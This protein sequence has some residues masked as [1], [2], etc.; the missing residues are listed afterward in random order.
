MLMYDI[1]RKKRD[2]EELSAAEIA[3]WIKGCV[4]GTIPDYQTTALLMAGRIR[5]FSPAETL[6]MVTNMV[7]SGEKVYL[8]D[9]PGVK[10]DKHS[11]GGVGDKTSMVVM[12]IVAAAGLKVAKISGRGIG[13]TGGTLD[14][15]QSIPGFRIDLTV[16]EFK[17]QVREIG[18][19]ITGQT[20][21]L[22]PADKKLYALR[23]LTATVDSIPLVAASIMSKKIAT[24]ADVLVLDVKFGSGAVFEDID[25]S[26]ELAR[27][28]VGLAHDS[29]I[30]AAA[31]LT[32]MNQPLGHTVGNALEV[33]EILEVLRGGGPDDLREISLTIAAE[34]LLLGKVAPDLA[35]AKKIA[36]QHLASGAALAKFI[37]MVEAQ[38]GSSDFSRLAQAGLVLP[39]K[40]KHG[41]YIAAIDTQKIGFA[42]LYVGAGRTK[43]EDEVDHATGLIL[44]EKLGALV[45]EGQALA[46]IH[47]RSRE[48][49][50]SA[51]WLL[52]DAFGFSDTPPEPQPLIADIIR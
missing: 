35:E 49:F 39:Y 32:S 29:G 25:R 24:G 28:M 23:D 11:T 8:G 51:S 12:P 10:A 15:L 33:K 43:K 1:I 47:C 5:G 6:S 17:A 18:I 31:V 2:S 13:H 26:R 9:I 19:A 3:F 42:A 20:A 16:D 52:D 36:A 40:A 22:V 37:A 21:E 46:D 4:N 45:K 27:I 38:G 48:Q 14:K 50:A 7:N 30:K 34:L 41:G 44:K